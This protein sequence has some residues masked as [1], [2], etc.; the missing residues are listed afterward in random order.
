MTALASGILRVP[1]DEPRETEDH[2]ATTTAA[3]AATAVFFGCCIFCTTGQVI[4]YL[5]GT[6]V[7]VRTMMMMM[8]MMM[9]MAFPHYY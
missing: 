9:M 6:S 2:L 7:E 3:A 5:R 8:L 1:A 4:S